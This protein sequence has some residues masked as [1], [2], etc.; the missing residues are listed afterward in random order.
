MS[1]ETLGKFTNVANVTKEKLIEVMKSGKDILHTNEQQKTELASSD[2]ENHVSEIIEKM[3]SIIPTYVKASSDL[4]K[5]YLHIMT[6]FYD[7]Y[8][9]NQ[10]ENLDKM[11]VNDEV[12]AMFDTYLKSIKEIFLLQ[13]DVNEN[14]VKKYVGHRLSVLD[15]YDQMI[16]GNVASFTKMLEKFKS[17][18]NT[19][20]Q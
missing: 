8:Y 2:I 16:N 7:S 13:I 20:K 15:V 11:G 19:E 10:K 5:K 12:L 18:K 6:N 9:F 1:E 4:Y 17:L 3:E 14:M